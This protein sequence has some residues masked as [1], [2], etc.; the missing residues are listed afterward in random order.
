M[1]HAAMT[2]EGW[3][4]HPSFGMPNHFSSGLLGPWTSY[5]NTTRQWANPTVA[6]STFPH[7]HNP[8][9]KDNYL[10]WLVN[11]FR[12]SKILNKLLCPATSSTAIGR[13]DPLLTTFCWYR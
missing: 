11:L 10:G 3:Q 8:L 7:S 4:D 1:T 5:V 12:P 6:S 9:D 13:C 2:F